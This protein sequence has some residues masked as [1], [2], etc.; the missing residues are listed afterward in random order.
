MESLIKERDVYKSLLYSF[1]LYVSM[2]LILKTNKDMQEQMI[3]IGSIPLMNFP[4]NFFSK[5]MV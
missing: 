3:F 4:R 2:G 1:E 5:W